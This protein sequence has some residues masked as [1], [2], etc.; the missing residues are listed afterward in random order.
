MNDRR[1]PR[2]KRLDFTTSLFCWFAVD[3]SLISI[4]K[5]KPLRRRKY[6]KTPWQFPRRLAGLHSRQSQ[7]SIFL[8]NSTNENRWMP[9][10]RP[11]NRSR[12]EAGLVQRPPRIRR[13]KAVKT[14]T[15]NSANSL[16]SRARIFYRTHSAFVPAL[17]GSYS[18]ARVGIWRFSVSQRDQQQIS[19]EGVYQP[20]ELLLSTGAH[21]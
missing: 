12:R 17:E 18:T 21:E 14:L 1:C 3:D 15:S 7:R 8:T 5:M 2:G 9:G 13:D 10:G 16:L 20:A 19:G 11:A 4:F 6:Y